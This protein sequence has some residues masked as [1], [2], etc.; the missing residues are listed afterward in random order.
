MGTAGINT[1]DTP[2]FIDFNGG[3]IEATANAVQQ[4]AVHQLHTNSYLIKTRREAMSESY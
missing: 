4:S 3:E 1:S 2:V